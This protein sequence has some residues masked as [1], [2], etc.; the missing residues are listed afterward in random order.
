MS[1]E[2]LQN[3][4]EQY[5]RH[6]ITYKVV[7]GHKITVDVLIPQ[8]EH[9]TPALH[10]RG[11][12]LVA[13]FHG[14][15]LVTGAS[16]YPGFLAPWNF[17]FAQRH[18]AIMVFP[19]Y[20]L[21]PESDAADLLEDL[22]DFW[23]WVAHDLQAFMSKTVE[24]CIVNLQ[25]VV[26]IGDSAG[27]FFAIQSGLMIDQLP[28]SI[29]IRGIV[30][31]FP[32][33]DLEDFW[34]TAPGHRVEEKIRGFPA[35]PYDVVT[36]H[37]KTMSRNIPIIPV[38]EDWDLKRHDL[39]I[40]AIRHG[41]FT[42]LFVGDKLIRD[43]YY[44]MRRVNSVTSFPPLIIMHGRQD[45]FVPVEGSVRFVEALKEKIP[46]VDVR[47]EIHD[48]EHGFGNDLDANSG[49]LVTCFEWMEGRMGM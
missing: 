13:K 36:D 47:L 15:G 16:L 49:W 48:G 12:P 33:V 6:T 35:I 9:T 38:S 28:S 26:I 5:K 8:D 4:I 24:G 37:I 31:P 32:M 1:A 44:P 30:A 22:A 18:S 17:Q 42:R 29:K 41:A 46:A 20:R 23:N 2:A 39:I 27:G 40:A 11:V 10:G 19:N 43:E 45:S 34:F 14:G 25:K 3:L 21:L 7:Q